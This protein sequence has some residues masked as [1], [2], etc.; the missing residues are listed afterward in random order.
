MLNDLAKAMKALDGKK[1]FCPVVYLFVSSMASVDDGTEAAIAFNPIERF[2]VPEWLV[3]FWW[4]FCFCGVG[5]LCLVFA[6]VCFW[7]VLF[8]F[9]LPWDYSLDYV[10][11]HNRSFLWLS[12][13]D[14]HARNLPFSFRQVQ[15]C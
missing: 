8:V 7:V 3:S 2:A 5:F 11:V 13:L 15:T 12:H 6:V 14:S 4:W 10:Q 1:L 9:S